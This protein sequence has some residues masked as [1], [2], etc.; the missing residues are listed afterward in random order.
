MLLPA[1]LGGSTPCTPS[2][3]AIRVVGD[4][5]GIFSSSNT[6]SSGGITRFFLGNFGDFLTGIAGGIRISVS[7]PVRTG[8]G[9]V[10]PT[11]PVG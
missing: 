4:G 6:T 2:S 11:T 3:I 5:I 10:W 9:L 7:S 8:N 1:L